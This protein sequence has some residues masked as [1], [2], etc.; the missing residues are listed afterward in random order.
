MKLSIIVPL[1]NK[2]LYIERC[3]K[4]LLAQDL[5]QYQ[6]E[7]I[8]VDDGSTDAGGSI[9]LNYTEMHTNV[10]CFQQ[11][12]KG[13]G[14]SRNRG[15]DFAKGVYVYFMDSDDYLA[16][17]TLA[18]V[19]GLCF[20]NQ[21]EILEFDTKK[22]NNHEPVFN[23]SETTIT[24][25]LEVMDGMVYIS[26]FGFVTE[27][28]RYLVKRELLTEYQ[29]RFK[30]YTLFEDVIFNASLFLKAKK[31]AKVAMDVHRY[32]VVE[33]SIVT[34]KDRAHNLKFIKGMVH[35]IEHFQVL[36]DHLDTAD[37]T[38]V[39]V[40]NKIKGR[41]HMMAFGLIIRTLKYHP[42]NFKQLK[43]IL[44]ELKLLGVYPINLKIEGTGQE[45]SN[46]VYNLFV[47]IF[48]NE[49]LLYASMGLTRF[50]NIR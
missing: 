5:P 16:E 7:I 23:T 45:T 35:A 33:N 14:A 38:C 4:S 6:Y 17:D 46:W 44:S 18:V 29:I 13:I 8:I 34:S 47:P 42:I 20:E 26:K 2:E 24:P 22:T 27:A 30:E 28:W 37:S 36:L 40:V 39:A 21:V 15:L 41:Q 32:V 3:L 11:Q 25:T 10:Y 12:N 49:V 50:I 48:N 19:L 43:K 1:F 9:A 31:V